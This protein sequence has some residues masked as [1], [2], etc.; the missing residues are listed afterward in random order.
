MDVTNNEQYHWHALPTEQHFRHILLLPALDEDTPIECQ[1]KTIPFAEPTTLM[2]GHSEPLNPQYEALSYTWGD[3]LLVH[4]IQCDGKALEVR[5]N[6]FMAL[7]RLRQPNTTRRLWIDAVCIDQGNEDERNNQVAQMAKIYRGAT[8]VVIWTGEDSTSQDGFL[9]MSFIQQA[10]RIYENGQLRSKIES[11]I[12]ELDLLCRQ[13]FGTSPERYDGRPKGSEF[14]TWF[15]DDPAEPEQLQTFLSRPWFSRRWVI[16]EMFNARKGILMCGKHVADWDTFS[17]YLCDFFQIRIWQ[18]VKNRRQS[19]AISNAWQLLLLRQMREHRRG[20]S[21]LNLMEMFHDFGCT[22][23][24]DRIWALL[25]V[26]LHETS[27]SDELL[28]DYRLNVEETFLAFAKHMVTIG[29]VNWLLDSASKRH[30]GSEQWRRNFLLPSWVPDWRFSTRIDRA[31]N[32][33]SFDNEKFSHSNDAKFYAEDG[34]TILIRNGWLVDSI[35][36]VSFRNGLFCEGLDR[37]ETKLGILGEAPRNVEIM[38]EDVVC[39]FEGC[40][41][42]FLLRESQRQPDRFVLISNCDLD[43]TASRELYRIPVNV[44]KESATQGQRLLHIL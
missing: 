42:P 40:D 20:L 13:V 32:D 4:R 35:K 33:H 39:F 3:A 44:G 9:T 38:E 7:R 29:K 21:F 22:D 26:S 11:L 43:S 5:N 16:Q 25:S 14:L 18:D 8:Q 17:A 27:T 10:A 6:L 23:E 2:E 19:E 24:R 12:K 28:P 15:P 36:S 1:M 41:L 31:G 37:I 34:D 30:E